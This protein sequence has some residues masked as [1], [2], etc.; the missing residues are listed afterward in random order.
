MEME[1]IKILAQS[2]LPKV[3]HGINPRNIMGDKA[4]NKIKKE[5]Q[6]VANHHCM[7]CNE[8]VPHIP[9]NYLECHE[10]Y[11]VDISNHIYELVDI[12]CIC[13]KCHEYIHFGRLQMLLKEG[14]ITYEYYQEIM[15]R[16]DN[17]LSQ[18]NLK[19]E[20]FDIKEINN[21]EWRLKYNGKFYSKD[22]QF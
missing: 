7:I 9:G 15:D 16:G 3:I 22:T 4:W 20:I 18:Y 14:K 19:K 21:T 5:K 11:D 2:P 17:I 13:R 12:V 6:T 1:K 10:V 8:Y